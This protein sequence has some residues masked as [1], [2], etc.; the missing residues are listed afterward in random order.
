MRLWVVGNGVSNVAF[1]PLSW[2]VG[3]NKSSEKYLVKEVTPLCVYHKGHLSE[4]LISLLYVCQI[5]VQSLFGHF[6][7]CKAHY[8]W[9]NLLLWEY[10]ELFKTWVELKSTCKFDLYIL[11]IPSRAVKYHY[12]LKWQDFIYLKKLYF[13]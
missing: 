12:I 2:I 1:W 9:G 11:L 4:I 10:Y 8:L 7:S 5:V 13:P 6:P 3:K